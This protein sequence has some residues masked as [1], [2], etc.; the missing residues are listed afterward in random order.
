[1]FEPVQPEEKIFPI[2]PTEAANW[3]CL[4]LDSILKYVIDQ[5]GTTL[6]KPRGGVSPG[7]RM[8]VHMTLTRPTTW[9]S[10]SVAKFGA[11]ARQ[12][13]LSAS[14]ASETSSY[15]AYL[16]RL[17]FDVTESEAAG[18][19]YVHRNPSLFN[20]GDHF[21]VLDIGGATSDISIL[22]VQAL[23]GR[24]ASIKV[25]TTPAIQGISKGGCD[26]TRKWQI[27]VRDHLR[28][29]GIEQ[30]ST[31][32]KE[33]AMVHRNELY[34][35]S[36]DQTYPTAHKIPGYSRARSDPTANIS[37][38]QLMMCV[39]VLI[40]YMPELTKTLSAN[41]GRIFDAALLD[42]IKFYI[43]NLLKT[44]TYPPV[45]LLSSS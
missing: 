15:G 37:H 7:C 44:L 12:A 42:P 24:L 6:H 33:M 3:S 40:L 18:S 10:A 9:D 11:I 29:A 43:E 21:M 25:E 20:H 26:I 35:F 23:Q 39:S 16:K 34:R 28:E 4:F 45:S 38:G 2:G 5:I 31:K 19:Y 27:Q 41:T 17:E 1:M 30:P 32:A 8:L 22:R 13:F 14:Q 36:C